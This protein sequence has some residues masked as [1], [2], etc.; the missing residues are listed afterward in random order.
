MSTI[1]HNRSPA[2]GHTPGPLEAGQISV[3]AEDRVAYIANSEGT[4]VQLFNQYN[5]TEADSR[6]IP[7]DVLPISRIGDTPYLPLDTKGDFKGAVVPT[8]ATYMLREP[9]GSLAGLRPG[10][11][12]AIEGAFYFYSRTGRSDV[13]SDFIY[14]DTPYEPNFLRNDSTVQEYVRSI[15]NCN[16]FGFLAIIGSLLNGSY[17]RYWWIHTN[18]TLDPAFHTYVDVTDTMS[19]L[20][21]LQYIKEF[22]GFIGSMSSGI[23]IKFYN[24]NLPINYVNNPTPASTTLTPKTV[25]CTHPI[26]GAVTASSTYID[27]NESNYSPIFKPINATGWNFSNAVMFS[28]NN[29]YNKYPVN[30]QL[31]DDGVTLSMFKNTS[32]YCVYDV[33][34]I[35]TTFVI[36]LRLNLTT[37]TISWVREANGPTAQD[38]PIVFNPLVQGIDNNTSTGDPTSDAYKQNKYPIVFTTVPDGNQYH[39]GTVDAYNFIDN[40]TIAIVSN[41]YA[42][43][44][45]G[46]DNIDVSEAGTVNK[47]VAYTDRPYLMKGSVTYKQRR[48]SQIRF[49][50]YDAS[51]LGKRIANSTFISRNRL[52]VDTLSRPYGQSLVSRKVVA[53]YPTIAV[54]RSLDASPT[55]NSLPIPDFTTLVDDVTGVSSIPE[56]SQFYNTC[57]TIIYSNGDYRVMP[58]GSQPKLYTTPQASMDGKVIKVV[59]GEAMTYDSTRGGSTGVAIYPTNTNASIDTILNS[60]I[61]SST[62]GFTGPTVT[63]KKYALHYIGDYT[64]SGTTYGLMLLQYTMQDIGN[65]TEMAAVTL[66]L[67]KTGLQLAFNADPLTNIVSVAKTVDNAT[68]TGNIYT[69]DVNHAC[70]GILQY[71]DGR[72]FIEARG[73]ARGYPGAINTTMSTIEMGAD[74][75]IMR[76]AIRYS[77]NNTSFGPNGGV[78]PDLG[79]IQHYSRYDFSQARISFT[80]WPNNAASGVAK[81]FAGFDGHL[82]GTISG[83]TAWQLTVES[84]QG[85]FLYVTQFGAFLNGRVYQ[86]PTMT[87]DLHQVITDPSSK[88]FYLYLH[89][90]SSTVMNIEIST[91]QMTETF[92]RIYMG[93]CTTSATGILNTTMYK[94]TRLDLFRPSNKPYVGSAMPVPV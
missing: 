77:E 39:A 90:V 30:Y 45:F 88:T 40:H 2:S 14:T 49:V 33:G 61:A 26:T 17:L 59:D 3:N 67:P 48:R 89:A 57:N 78:H 56:M 52:G 72:W 60:Y 31:S 35:Y 53:T 5:K 92:D 66:R 55:P 87:I 8:R 43:Y 4:N 21:S 27:Y 15:N 62:L 82:G 9:D 58:Y 12:G 29:S 11:N 23:G 32:I 37:N 76:S 94:T 28:N 85:F 54:N 36:R 81:A 79:P 24:N 73:P 65:K 84:S 69:W 74:G 7:L 16:Q 93:I 6:Y 75:T 64:N 91:T 51:I 19:S 71:T 22:N 34:G 42:F 80:Y 41:V 63:A 70:I 47:L 86:V 68:Q 1:E 38:F 44:T 50:P 20:I 13:E 18:G 25:N 46:L 10:Y 83:S